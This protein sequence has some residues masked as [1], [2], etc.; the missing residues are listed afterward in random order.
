MRSYRPKAG[1]ASFIFESE[2]QLED[3]LERLDSS[4][5][6]L[7]S[8]SQ[9]SGAQVARDARS[10]I[11]RLRRALQKISHYPLHHPQASK[12]VRET[13]PLAIKALAAQTS[14]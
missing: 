11:L 4:A 10:E 1:G 13:A 7:N 6:H 8:A 9:P 14:G 3:I 2:Q 5:S 12:D